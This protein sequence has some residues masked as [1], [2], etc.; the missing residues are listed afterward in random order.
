MF[1]MCLSHSHCNLFMI[2][3]VVYARVWLKIRAFCCCICIVGFV[4]CMSLFGLHSCV[5]KVRRG[6]LMGGCTNLVYEDC[7]MLKLFAYSW[8]LLLLH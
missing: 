5:I 8:T 3:M 7:G 4:V 1:S 6:V 2:I